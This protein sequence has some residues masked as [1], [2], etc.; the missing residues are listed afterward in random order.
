[1]PRTSSCCSDVKEGR[2]EVV[3]GT[4]ATVG[5]EARAV[6]GE[7]VALAGVALGPSGVGD[8]EGAVSSDLHAASAITN[9]SEATKQ[10]RTIT[11]AA[12]PAIPHSSHHS[13]GA[14]TWCGISR[15]TSS[16]NST[17][18]ANLPSRYHGD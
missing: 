10:T 1:M 9:A 3:V 16:P 2:D 4:D 12:I 18:P 11:L 13:F 17:S 5:V 14:R 6:A 7:V 15:G 8:V